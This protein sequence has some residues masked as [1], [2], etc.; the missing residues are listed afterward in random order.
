MK[1]EQIIKQRKIRE[2]R[3]NERKKL[4]KWKKKKLRRSVYILNETRK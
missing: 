2:Q 3:K 1:L 4:D